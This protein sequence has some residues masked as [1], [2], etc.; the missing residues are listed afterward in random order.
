MPTTTSSQGAQFRTGP[1]AAQDDIEQGDTGIGDTVT[2][3]ATVAAPGVVTL[4]TVAA[5]AGGVY[6]VRAVVALTGT[7][8]TQLVN[9]QFR[10]ASFHSAIPALTG[11]VVVMEWPRITATGNMILNVPV[12]ATAGSIYTASLSATRVE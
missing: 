2:T 12:I 11:Q 10:A 7:A 4:V 6:R 1:R 8:E 9:V 5:T 3:T